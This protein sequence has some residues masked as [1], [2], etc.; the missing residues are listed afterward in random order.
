VWANSGI[1][2][3]LGNLAGYGNSAAG[4][5]LKIYRDVRVVHNV[6]LAQLSL[7]SPFRLAATE[8]SD[9]NIADKRQGDVSICAHTGVP[10]EVRC[11]V[12]S[13]L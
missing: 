12:Y 8:A 7:D 4:V 3:G 6:R 1:E 5:F 11:A 9:S 2:T 13:D 10:R